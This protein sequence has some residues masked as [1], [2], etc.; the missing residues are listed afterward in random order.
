[1]KTAPQLQS[2]RI[3]LDAMHAKSGFIGVVQVKVMILRQLTNGKQTGRCAKRQLIFCRFCRPCREADVRRV[4]TRKP[5][6]RKSARKKAPRDYANLHNGILPQTPEKGP[7]TESWLALLQE[8]EKSGA[9]VV[10]DSFR[11]MKGNEVTLDWLNEDDE[12]M[13]EPIVIESTEGLG[14]KMPPEGLT[15]DDVAKLVG[16]D[17]PVEV[18]GEL[19]QSWRFTQL[20][21]FQMS[22]H[23][24]TRQVT[25]LGNGQR[26]IVHHLRK[27]KRSS[28]SF[29]LKYQTRSSVHKSYHRASCEK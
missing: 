19:H 5:P 2:K 13:K 22:R 6:A 20:T 7:G 9:I 1:M 27:E 24:P 17:A 18:M 16:E 26:T 15:V 28:M 29:L 4:I 14:M 10:S 3:G 21:G 12:A 11:R 8:K 25:R 23:R